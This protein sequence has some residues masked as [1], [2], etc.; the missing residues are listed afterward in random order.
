MI[1][2]SQSNTT[3]RQQHCGSADHSSARTETTPLFFRVPSHA[4]VCTRLCFAVFTSLVRLFCI[5]CSFSFAKGRPPP[6]M[7]KLLLGLVL[8]A[9]V[10]EIALSAC[11]VSGCQPDRCHCASIEKRLTP[12]PPA[13]IWSKHVEAI[14][15]G[16]LTNGGMIVCPLNTT[17]SILKLEKYYSA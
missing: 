6:P 14:D 3:T 11:S 10:L 7:E 2:Q 17:R 16:C 1:D 13:Q 4:R 8:A 15:A 5:Y 9:N 12:S